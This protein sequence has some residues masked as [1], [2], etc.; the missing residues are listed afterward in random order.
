MLPNQL[1]YGSKVESAMAQSYRTNIAPQNGTGPYGL[2]Q[3]IIINVPTQNNLVLATTESYLKFC[4]RLYNGTGVAYGGTAAG[5]AGNTV[6]WDSCGAHSII[7]RLRVFSGSNLLEDI[8]NYGM[9][10][11]ILFD[12]QVSTDACYGR[13]N[14][15]AGTRNDLIVSGTSANQVNSGEG[16]SLALATSVTSDRYFCLNLISLLGSLNSKNY[17]PLFACTSAPIRL[18]IQ[19]VSNQYSAYYDATGSTPYLNNVEYVANFLK[20]SD[21]AMSIIN[22]SIPDGTP[23][24]FS[25]PQYSNYQY[26]FSLT[27][28][29]TQVNFPIPAKYSS[30]KSIFITC[31]DQGVGGITYF[32][33]SSV[34]LNILNY[35]FRIGSQIMPTKAPDNIPEMFA[36]LMKAMGSMSDLNYQPSIELA[37]YSGNTNT[38]IA[39]LSSGLTNSNSF[40]I[41]LDLEN[42][43]S[44]SKDSIFCGYNSNTDD[45]FAIMNFGAQ[46]ATTNTRFDAFAMFDSVISFENNTCYRKF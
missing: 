3:T 7:Q 38:P 27:T 21:S 26:T 20:L 45:I 42:Y 28:A 18:E 10:A 25:I 6:R 24:Q 8:D 43:V 34:A 30:L 39:T 32:P 11:K 23:L 17:F 35:Y 31:R 1:K 5:T 29:A 2:G 33:L 22:G 9:L 41:G 16:Y 14:V 37:S 4:F 46:G 36:E 40:Y 15:L 12:A 44:A 13:M 19:L